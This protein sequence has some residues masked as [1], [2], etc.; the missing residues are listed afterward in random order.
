MSNLQC[1]LRVH[2][3]YER[4]GSLCM[5]GRVKKVKIG[6]KKSCKI[7]LNF[8][9]NRK[10]SAAEIQPFIWMGKNAKSLSNFN[11][12]RLDSDNGTEQFD[13]ISLG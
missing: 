2:E 4:F 1:D 11:I 5:G 10:M 3:E 9:E 12:F 7:Q 6:V 8:K 13:P